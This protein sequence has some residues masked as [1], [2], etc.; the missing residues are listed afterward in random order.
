MKKFILVLLFA[1]LAF[2]FTSC[3]DLLDVE[4]TFTFTYSFSVDTDENAF[5]G[6][7]LINLSDDV[8]LI[9]E[10]GD[11]IK[12]VTIENVSFWLTEFN[13]PDTQKIESGSLQVSDAS[14]ENVQLIAALGSHLLHEL[15]DSPETLDISQAGLNLLNELA[16]NPPHSFR[17]HADIEVNEGPLDF[18]A[19]FEFTARMVANPLE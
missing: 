10:Y 19:V 14:D 9:A 2:L 7:Q 17:L 15:L 6:S 16:E 3:E 18:T 4:E 13:G 5:S 1:P 12:E 8:N 11:K